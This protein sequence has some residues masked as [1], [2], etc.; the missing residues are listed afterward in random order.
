MAD[1]HVL[2]EGQ[3][4]PKETPRNSKGWDGKLRLESEQES[5]KEEVDS[6]EAQK[7]DGTGVARDQIPADEGLVVYRCQPS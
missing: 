7:E 2:L 3:E 1:K 5:A 6:D 4:A